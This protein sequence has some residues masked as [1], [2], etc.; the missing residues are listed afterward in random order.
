M[1]TLRTLNKQW[2]CH[3]N[4]LKK[5]WKFRRQIVHIP[6]QAIISLYSPVSL[7]IF[8]LSRHLNTSTFFNL[9]C[10]FWRSWRIIIFWS[11]FTCSFLAMIRAL[12]SH[13]LSILNYRTDLFSV[14]E[15]VAFKFPL[16]FGPRWH[17]R[18]V[19]SLLIKLHYNYSV[20]TFFCLT[21]CF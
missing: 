16:W 11:S 1:F 18:V 8:T 20:N 6:G 12:W 10:Q 14:I 2:L 4:R 15:I 9:F 19:I 3:K 7:H 17:L 5:M 21:P 13:F